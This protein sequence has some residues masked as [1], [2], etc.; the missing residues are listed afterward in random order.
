MD[1]P[2]YQIIDR[3]FEGFVKNNQ[4]M[5]NSMQ[6]GEIIDLHAKEQHKGHTL[7]SIQMLESP[8]NVKYIGKSGGGEGP[9]YMFLDGQ[10]N[11]IYSYYDVM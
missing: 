3:E 6:D 2:I 8:Y 4:A 9:M 1:Q 10:F 7:C 11:K 5:L